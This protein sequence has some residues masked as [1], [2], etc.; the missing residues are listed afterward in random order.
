MDCM[1]KFAEDGTFQYLG[2][3]VLEDGIENIP[4]YK[5][6]IPAE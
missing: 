6:R 1:K 5:Y 3:K 2:N 4:D